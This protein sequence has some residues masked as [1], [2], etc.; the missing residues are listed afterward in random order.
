MTPDELTYHFERMRNFRREIQLAMYR[1]GMSAAY[2]IHYA[3]DMIDDEELIRRRTSVKDVAPFQ[4]R[5]PD[6]IQ[7]M[8]H[9]NDQANASWEHSPQNRETMREHYVQLVELYDA[10]QLLPLAYER[11]S[12]QSEKPLLDDARALQAFPRNAAE[13]IRLERILRL[14]IEDYLDIE[15]EIDSLNR[16]IDAEREA[17]VEGHR[18]LIHAYVHELGRHDEVS[19]AAARYAA[20]VATRMFDERRGFRFMPYAEVWIDRELKRV[21]DP[22]EK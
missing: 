16:Q 15:S 4:T 7:R 12:R 13:R 19:L 11:L 20:R 14:T 6:L 8:E 21:G 5:L 10:V 9:V 3:Q 22:E 18:E 17:V 2:H 1:M